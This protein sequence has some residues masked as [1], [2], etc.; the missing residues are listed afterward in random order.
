MPRRA[1]NHARVH[2][3]GVV[4]SALIALPVVGRLPAR[5]TTKTWGLD[6]GAPH[7]SERELLHVPTRQHK[8]VIVVT[9]LYFVVVV[10]HHEQP[11]GAHRQVSPRCAPSKNTQLNN[12]CSLAKQNGKKT[13][14]SAWRQQKTQL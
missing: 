11:Q 6:G 7:A 1:T 9:L 8:I 5:N 2:G 13:N 10:R 4:Q 14:K 12:D 3:A